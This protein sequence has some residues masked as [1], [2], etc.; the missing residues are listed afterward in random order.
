MRGNK[1]LINIRLNDGRVQRI[2][3]D[4]AGLLVE[5]ERAQF[6]SNTLYKAARAGIEVKP[7]MKDADIMAL[8][9]EAKATASKAKEKPQKEEQERQPQQKRKRRRNREDKRPGLKTPK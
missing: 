4:R 5:D 1:Q 3:R 6:I 9:R 2:P 8:V 7:G